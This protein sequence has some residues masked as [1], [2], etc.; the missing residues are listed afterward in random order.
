MPIYEFRCLRCQAVQE[1]LFTSN[2]DAYEM[3]CTS[4]GSEE[5]ERVLSVSHYS[6]GS[7]SAKPHASASTKKCSEGACSTLEIPGIGD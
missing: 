7:P 1:F 4:C 5:L 2:Q 6:M 3:V